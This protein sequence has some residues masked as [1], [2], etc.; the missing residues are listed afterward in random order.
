[1]DYAFA[2][3]ALFVTVGFYTARAVLPAADAALR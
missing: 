2:K 3:N 1:M